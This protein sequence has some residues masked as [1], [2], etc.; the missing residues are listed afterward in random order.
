MRLTLLTRVVVRRKCT[1]LPHARSTSSAFY[2]TAAGNWG[3]EVPR[4][5]DDHGIRHEYDAR[6]R[7]PKRRGGTGTGA[8]STQQS[9]PLNLKRR[10]FP[11]R[12]DWRQAPFCGPRCECYC[13]RYSPERRRLPA[14]ETRGRTS[15]FSGPRRCSPCF[16]FLKLG[17]YHVVGDN[18]AA[19]RREQCLCLNG[20]SS[21]RRDSMIVLLPSSRSA[22][23]R[24]VTWE[25]PR[26]LFSGSIGGGGGSCYQR[27]DATG[28]DNTTAT[29][30]PTHL[31]LTAATPDFSA[32]ITAAAAS[33]V[34][35]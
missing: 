23:T 19:S 22:Y 6:R 14:L 16:H 8:H 7:Q 34:Q 31:R 27:V 12:P 11:P 26:E 2:R 30:T 29:A 32:T 1:L 18:K 33:S 28:A 24:A 17:C 25:C 21:R 9:R 15:S 5:A 13:A 10:G 3:E 20:G 35:S 4:H